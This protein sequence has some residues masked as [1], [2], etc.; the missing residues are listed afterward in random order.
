MVEERI[1]ELKDISIENYKTE[2]LREQKLK[3]QNT[4]H[5]T[6]TS[7]YTKGIYNMCTMGITEGEETEEQRK[8]L[9]HNDG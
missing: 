7:I 1:S 9:K 4:D 8:Y 5:G 6:T 2:K 3:K